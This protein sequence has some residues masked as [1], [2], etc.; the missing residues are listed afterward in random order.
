MVADKIP[1][2]GGPDRWNLISSFVNRTV[3]EFKMTKDKLSGVIS[4]IQHDDGSGYSFILFLKVP[5]RTEDY[6]IYYDTKFKRGTL[7]VP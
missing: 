2:N 4:K 5:A 7:F 1:I 3:V 6:K